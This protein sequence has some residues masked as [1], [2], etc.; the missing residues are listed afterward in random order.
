VPTRKQRRRQQKLRRHE[1]EEVYVDDEGRELAPEEVEELG[2]AAAPATSAGARKAGA[3]QQ[4]QRGRMR[5]M[6]PPSW[7]RVLKRAAIFAPMMYIVISLLPGGG[8]LSLQAR[9]LQ[10][11]YL[12]LIFMPF[13][14]VMDSM[15][16]RLWKR[17]TER[18][19]A[20]PKP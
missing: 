7:K 18:A 12:I 19:A 16:Y 14:Y 10:T 9:L 8:D 6:Q 11:A 5:A 17:R 2:V 20:G 3:G 15:T 13:S 1:W 4:P